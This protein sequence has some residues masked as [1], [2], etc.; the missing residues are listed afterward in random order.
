MNLNS[1]GFK[2]SRI[3]LDGPR[4]IYY[5]GQVISGKIE[6]ELNQSL[7]FT[8]INVVYHGGASVLWTEPQTEIYSGVK[9]YTQ[10]EYRANEEYFNTVQHLC[11]GNGTSILHQ[12]SHS[13]PFEFQIP[14]SVP[15]SFTSPIGNV[16]YKISAYLEAP[17]LREE[18]ERTFEVVAPLDLNKDESGDAQQPIEMQ[19]EEMYSCCCST[20]PISIGVKLPVSGYC[21]GQPMPITINADNNSSTEISKIIFQLIMKERYHSRNPVSEYTPPEKLLATMKKGPIMGNSK[22]VYTF[23]MPVPEMIAPHLD[24]CGIIDLGY[25]FKVIIKLSGCNDDMEDES[26]IYIGLIPL[27]IT[28]RGNIYVHPMSHSLPK[29]PIPDPNSAP[30]FTSLPVY[31]SGG[32]GTENRSSS[33]NLVNTNSCTPYGS[34][35][36]MSTST[37]HSVNA[38]PSAPYPVQENP[39]P[40]EIG[41]KI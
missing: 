11:G 31:M 15:S 29:D 28:T 18:L 14:F 4:G 25:F 33:T 6:F 20:Q 26:E 21:P 9:R 41:F 13:I 2:N 5:S 16:T 39:R 27:E 3:S 30:N 10:V 24:N 35:S 34:R 19:F 22:R 17:P 36:N 37:V 32:M 38:M 40:Y 8:A 1:E 23:E 12:G 7:T